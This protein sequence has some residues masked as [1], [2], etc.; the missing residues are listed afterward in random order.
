MIIEI[1]KN[2][3][4]YQFSNEDHQVGDKV[5]PLGEGRADKDNWWLHRIKDNEFDESDPHIIGKI[6][7]YIRTQKGYGHKSI[8][9][10][11]IGKQLLTD[12]TGPSDV[13]KRFEWC[14][15]PF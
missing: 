13:F 4:R 6:D 1:T 14:D 9:F 15:I 7:D 3:I 2:R 10:K 12:V 11:L 8:Y 5:W